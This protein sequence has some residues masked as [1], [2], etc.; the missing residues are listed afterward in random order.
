VVYGPVL[1]TAPPQ[2]TAAPPAPQPRTV[3]IKGKT[4]RLVPL[5]DRGANDREELESQ[6]PAAGVAAT[7][8]A[9]D[10][11]NGKV[12]RLPKTTIFDGGPENFP[13]IT[14][15]RHTLQTDD[16]MAALGI[17]EGPGVDRVKQEKRNV[18]V[19][20]WIYAFRKESD[21]DYHVILGDAPDAADRLF[22]NAEVSGIPTAGSADNRKRLQAVRKAFQQTFDLGPDGPD[23]YFR[24]DPPVPVQVTGSLFWD[25]EHPPPHTVGPTDFAPKTAWEIHPISQI[26]FLD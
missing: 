20:A 22:L 3:T 7:I 26:D 8:P 2:A 14:A 5:T 25:V 11:F 10:R 16:E 24:P 17:G 9:T 4:Y 15:L 6:P 1:A 18:T 13:S 12:R 23:G 21:N 19:K